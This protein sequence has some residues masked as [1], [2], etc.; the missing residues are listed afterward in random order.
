MASEKQIAAN[1]RNA[2]SSTVAQTPE[3]KARSARNTTLRGLL[4]R[5]AVLPEEDMDAY[6]DLVADLEEY[7]RP[8]D[9]VEQFLVRDIVSAQWRLRRLTRIETGYLTVRM[10]EMR[11]LEYDEEPGEAE[12]PHDEET[13]LF[14]LLLRR[15]SGDALATLLRQENSLRRAWYKA[16]AALEKHRARNEP[17]PPAKEPDSRLASPR[18]LADPS[19]LSEPA[20]PQATPPPA[21][22]ALFVVPSLVPVTVP[23]RCTRPRPEPCAAE[24]S[25]G[26]RTSPAGRRPSVCRNT[27]TALLAAA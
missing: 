6:L 22:R 25:S 11:R 8:T 4:A 23:P 12:D 24:W 20:L 5:E 13:R 10:E 9:A 18:V 14:G 15:G 27:A 1:R 3:G 26:I 7:F 19:C 16:V 21:S 2:Q 17:K